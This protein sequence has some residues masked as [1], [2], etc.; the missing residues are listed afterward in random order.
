VSSIF[1]SVKLEKMEREKNIFDK[2]GSLIPGY[3][4]YAE[5]DGRRNCDKI[6]REAISL[7]LYDVERNL[8]QKMLDVLKKEG[9][10]KMQ[11]LEDLR[12][13]IN[14]LSSKIKFA[15]YGVSSFFADNQIKEDELSNVYQYDLNIVESAE[16]L[17]DLVKFDIGE[18]FKFE[19]LEFEN[20]LLKRN[21]Y[22]NGFK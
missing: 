5:R 14:T 7:K 9:V 16:K 1:L 6:L 2:I 4:G 13:H 11:E 19:V 20:Q 18:P 21:N 12:K 8:N 22:L 15:P 3:A 10:K 17:G